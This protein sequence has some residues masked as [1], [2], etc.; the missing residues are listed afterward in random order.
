MRRRNVLWDN[1][2]IQHDITG[3]MGR[4]YHP[5]APGPEG[6]EILDGLEIL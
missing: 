6:C 5:G 1:G 3:E 4:Q 2:I